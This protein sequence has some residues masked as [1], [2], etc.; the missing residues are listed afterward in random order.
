MTDDTLEPRM[1]G[2]DRGNSRVVMPQGRLNHT[3]ADRF[4]ALLGDQCDIAIRSNRHVIIDLSK[5]DYLSSIIL[6]TVRSHKDLL[7]A[8][9]L[10]LALCCP[11]ASVREIL[12]IAQFH[13]VAQLYDTISQA[14]AAIEEGP[15]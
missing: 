2:S 12:N 10:R 13:Y 15:G 3:N 1:A 14:E 6:K 8:Q 11:T 5:V 9:E 7:K 4:E